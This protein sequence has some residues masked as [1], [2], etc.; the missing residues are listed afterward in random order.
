MEQ[1][2]QGQAQVGVVAALWCCTAS[3]GFELAIPTG[4]WPLR[5]EAKLQRGLPARLHARPA[6]GCPSVPAVVGGDCHSLRHSVARELVASG[7]WSGT[8]SEPAR[9]GPR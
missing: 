3:T 6:A 4:R 8:L 5:P 2:G 9:L 7:C 1:V